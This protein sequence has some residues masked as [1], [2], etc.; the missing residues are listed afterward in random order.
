[1][2]DFANTWRNYSIND[3]AGM[4]ICTWPE[5]KT[6]PIMPIPYNGETMDGFQWAAAAHMIMNGMVEEGLT[7][8]KS[9]R[10]RYDGRKRNPWNEFECGSNYARSLASYA[11]LNA[12]SG[13]TFDTTRKMIGFNPVTTGDFRCFWSL[14]H[15]WGEFNRNDQK[16]ELSVLHGRLEIGELRIEGSPVRLESGQGEHLFSTHA[17]GVF[18]LQQPLAMTQDDQLHIIFEEL[19]QKKKHLQ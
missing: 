9:I 6:K 19:V 1:M 12:F 18:V 15:A 7:V 13:F 14:G 2:R 17:N 11:L 16:A 5:G 3:E 8:V 10:N 4:V